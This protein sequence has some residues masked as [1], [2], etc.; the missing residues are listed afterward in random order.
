MADRVLAELIS[1]LRPDVF[2][3]EAALT[4]IND[5]RYVPNRDACLALYA[6][7]IEPRRQNSYHVVGSVEHSI[8]SASEFYELYDLVP[9]LLYEERSVRKITD[10][11]SV[12]EN[13]IQYPFD[14]SGWHRTSDLDCYL[15]L[16]PTPLEQR[17]IARDMTIIC[18]PETSDMNRAMI[19][20]WLT[21]TKSF[22][23]WR[24]E[25]VKQ[26][27]Y[28]M[29]EHSVEMNKHHQPTVILQALERAS[30]IHGFS[31]ND[32]I[33]YQQGI[34]QSIQPTLFSSLLTSVTPTEM[35]IA[36]M[37]DRVIKD[38]V[39]VGGMVL[40]RADSDHKKK[41]RNPFA[42]PENMTVP[43]V[44]TLVDDSEVAAAIFKQMEE[45]FVKE[46]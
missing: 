34:I 43:P 28:L 45:S 5:M 32:R 46:K 18:T 39:A 2:A 15:Q 30:N 24:R 12:L 14:F 4:I 9:V 7:L 42:Y 1:V 21:E 17:E 11:T 13:L 6:T 29:N 26:A 8:P 16:I 27:V 44:F 19:R 38:E 33:C 41:R 10:I 37:I 23:L 3:G 20:N 31:Q 35:E 40:I 36:G 22:P 25:T